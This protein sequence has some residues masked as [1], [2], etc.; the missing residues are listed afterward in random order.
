MTVNECHLSY[1]SNFFR[2]LLVGIQA[3]IQKFDS[4]CLRVNQTIEISKLLKDCWLIWRKEDE[5]RRKKTAEEDSLY[6]F[7]AKIHHIH[8]D[9]VQEQEA[10]KN[11]FPLYD[12]IRDKESN[13]DSSMDE[14]KDGVSLSLTDSSESLSPEELYQI[15]G[16]HLSLFGNASIESTVQ[17]LYQPPLDAYHLASYLVHCLQNLP[18]N[19]HSFV[20]ATS[21]VT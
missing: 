11:I 6:L 9:E 21:C 14:H 2:L 15:C 13:D 8:S 12:V 4:N 7:K 3:S 1:A 5:E 19:C 10:L 18:G 16:L 20:L 17:V